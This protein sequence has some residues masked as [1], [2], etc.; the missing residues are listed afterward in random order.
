MKKI[1]LTFLCFALSTV[2]ALAADYYL[3]RTQ[4]IDGEYPKGGG[5]APTVY[6]LLQPTNQQPVVFQK[7][8]SWQMESWLRLRARGSVV[9]Y[10]S[11]ALLLPS[12]TAAEWEGFTT[13]C[14]TN[15]I[16]LLNESDTD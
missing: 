12:P 15:D 5:P 1:T 10:H 7:F 14:K 8:N 6:V 13:F 16:T 4:M 9:H 11:S 2:F 3:I